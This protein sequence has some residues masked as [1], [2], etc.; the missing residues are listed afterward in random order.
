MTD[1]F[2]CFAIAHVHRAYLGIDSGSQNPQGQGSAEKE[3]RDRRVM[4]AAIRLC[5][6]QIKFV[7]LSFYGEQQ[8]CDNGKLMGNFPI[9]TYNVLQ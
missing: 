7:S 3:L 6:L 5:Q 4:F 8:H 2:M 9:E 1:I